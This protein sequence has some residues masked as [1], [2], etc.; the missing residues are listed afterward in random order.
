VSVT[1]L[2]ANRGYVTI[3]V[4][5]T[6][7]EQYDLHRWPIYGHHSAVVILQQASVRPPHAILLL[8]PRQIGKS[9]LMRIF[10]QAA[11][12]TSHGW[13]PCGVCRACRLMAKGSHPDF[14]VI[15]PVDKSG[16]IDRLDGMLRVEQAAELIREAA[17]HPVEGQYKIF[18]LQDFQAANDAFANKLLKTLE[19][20]PDHVVLCLTAV[21]RASI[22]PTIAS[23]CQ[24]YNL[25]PLDAQTITRALITGWQADAEQAQLLGRLANGRLG[26]AVQQL[27]QPDGQQERLAQLQAL[28]GLLS[29]TRMERLNFAERLAANRNS[30]QLFSLLE[31]WTTW[32]RDVLLAQSG[33]VDLCSNIDQRSEIERQGRLLA[34][35]EV[36]NY[37]QKL[38][39]VEGYL[40]HTVNT[41]LALDVLLL[42]AP[43]IGE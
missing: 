40:H 7:V 22:L 43:S 14:R 28:W 21:D 16:E 11:L 24:I 18:L 39:Q 37:L 13:R 25:H 12:C 2:V 34:R 41:R 10:A 8:G 9:T 42:Q 29:A 27:K 38:R 1:H 23:R 36:Q 19:E 30:L 5:D 33:C 17:L 20:P 31:V 4:V 6:I 3:H 26:W 35:H 32:W 15:A